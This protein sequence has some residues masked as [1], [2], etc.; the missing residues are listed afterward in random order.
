MFISI[1]STVTPAMLTTTL[2]CN[3]KWVFILSS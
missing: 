2:K 1:H 3:E